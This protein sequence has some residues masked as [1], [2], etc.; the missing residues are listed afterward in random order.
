[1]DSSVAL[2]LLQ[3]AE[4]GW[5]YIIS[6]G[7]DGTSVLWGTDTDGDGVP[8]TDVTDWLITGGDTV[9]QKSIIIVSS[10]GTMTIYDESGN[11]TAEDCDTAYQLWISDNGIMDKPFD[12]YTV[13]DGLLLILVIF[14]VINFF[15]GLFRRREVF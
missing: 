3:L 15:K 10:D 9:V 14:A 2:L 5:D 12:N 1:M 11:I 13:T 8:D 6:D 4:W 7:D